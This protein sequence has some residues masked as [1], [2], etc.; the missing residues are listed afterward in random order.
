MVDK[1][2][3]EESD[4]ELM[5]ALISL[6]KEDKHYRATIIKEKMMAYQVQKNRVHTKWLAYVNATQLKHAFANWIFHAYYTGRVITAS[7]L[8]IEIG[9]S[10]KA[11]DEMVSD[12]HLE[13]WLIKTKGLDSNKNKF[14]LTPTEEPLKHQQE[15]YDW[16]EDSIQ[17]LRNEAYSLLMESRKKPSNPEA[18]FDTLATTNMRG[19]ESSVSSFIIDPKKRVNGG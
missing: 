9:C 14:Y 17:P 12:W 15:W 4:A 1:I 8:T 18:K 3:Y 10:R 7:L 16:Y 19:I 6:S 11:I 13:G 2:T 5:E